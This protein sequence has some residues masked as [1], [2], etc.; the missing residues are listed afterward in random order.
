MN[1]YQLSAWILHQKVTVVQK[2]SWGLRTP[3]NAQFKE[4][5]PMVLVV[6]AFGVQTTSY[7]VVLL[8]RNFIN[9]IALYNGRKS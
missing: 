9:I 3:P 7:A 6:R 8:K 5:K 1:T 2:Y 4:R